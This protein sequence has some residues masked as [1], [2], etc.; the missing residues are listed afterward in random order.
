MHIFNP[1]KHG[2]HL[3]N[4]KEFRHDVL[5]MADTMITVFWDVTPCSSIDRQHRFGRNC[6]FHLQDRSVNRARIRYCFSSLFSE[7]RFLSIHPALPLNGPTYKNFFPCSYW[8]ALRP[9]TGQSYPCIVN[10]E[11]AGS[12]ESQTVIFV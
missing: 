2:F 3:N 7:S 8:F 5:M 6:R 4:V 9:L 10:M 1:L 12:F 11:A